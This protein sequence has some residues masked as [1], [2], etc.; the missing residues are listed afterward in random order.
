MRKNRWS[1]RREG[2]ST[3]QV[4]HLGR[5]HGRTP[6]DPAFAEFFKGVRKQRHNVLYLFIAWGDDQGQGTT[7]LAIWWPEEEMLRLLSKTHFHT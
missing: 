2:D 7:M 6:M 5:Q 4:R 3:V 1:V